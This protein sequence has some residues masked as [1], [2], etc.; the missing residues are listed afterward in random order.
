MI[1]TRDRLPLLRE[2]VASVRGQDQPSWELIVVDD[3]SSDGTPAWVD[4]VSDSRVRCIRVGN[5]IERSAARNRGL[6][7]A[8]APLI[9]FLDDDDRL[10][11]SA[12]RRLAHGLARAPDALAAF[13]AKEVFDGTGHRKRIPHP[14][15]P[16]VRSVWDDVMA[17]WMFVS[18]QVLLRT[19]AVRAAGGWDERLAMSEDQDLWLRVPGRR[20]AVLVPMV[21]LDQRTRPQGVDAAEV[22]DEVRARVVNS[23]TADERPRAACLIDARRHLRAAGRAFD[24][25]DFGAA[26]CELVAAARTAPWLLASPIWAPPL[27]LSTAKAVAAAALPGRVGVH[28]RHSV[29][30]VRTRLG[31]NPFEPGET[32]I[33]RSLPPP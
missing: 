16:L 20:P 13:G 27:V 6:A 2:A 30:R 4:A 19:D 29:R 18:G 12:L 15:V 33:G 32:P 26:R 28:A 5:R 22:E 31:R 11:P 24:A 7:E 21:V 8:T 23:L 25:E 9:L 17:G 3:A 1:P 10:R 14:R